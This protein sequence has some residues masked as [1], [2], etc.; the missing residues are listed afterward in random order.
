MRS[1]G[2]L[3]YIFLDHLAGT[4]V[5]SSTTSSQVSTMVYYPYGGSRFS[6]G[7]LPTDR[8]YTGQVSD[9]ST[10]LYDYGARMYSA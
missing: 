1:C 8:L 9:S 3:S 7:A 10:G 2:A 4:S 5:V 6:T